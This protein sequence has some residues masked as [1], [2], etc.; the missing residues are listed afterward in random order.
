MSYEYSESYDWEELI[1]T[2]NN[3]VNKIADLEAKLAESETRI[4]NLK[5]ANN[6][7][8]FIGDYITKYLDKREFT[9][10][11]IEDFFKSFEKLKQQLAEK[12][13]EIEQWKSMAERS[14]SVLD[15]FNYCGESIIYN[16]TRE[17]DKISFAVDILEELADC[18]NYINSKLDFECGSYVSEKAIRDKIEYLKGKKDE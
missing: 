18:S 7:F 1:D 16:T 9:F 2:L 10:K 14:S 12:D 15:R 3:Q 4:S 11:D 5:E 17:Q 6:T 13:A 8:S